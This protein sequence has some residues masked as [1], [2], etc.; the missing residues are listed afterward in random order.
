VKGPHRLEIL[1]TL[2][3]SVGKHQDR[4]PRGIAA[5]CLLLSQPDKVESDV[6]S[7]TWR[8]G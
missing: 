1:E 7:L 4:R 2:G 3:K 8:V 6:A 5:L